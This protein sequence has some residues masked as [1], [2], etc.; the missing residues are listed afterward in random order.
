MAS[1]IKRV[2]FFG[3]GNVE[4]SIA[5]TSPVNGNGTIITSMLENSIAQG[6][7]I[8][9]KS[10]EVLIKEKTTNNIYPVA[11]QITDTVVPPPKELLLNKLFLNPGD[12]IVCNGANSVLL[13]KLTKQT[14]L[15]YLASY[16]GRSA[17]VN[18]DGSVL[19][20]YGAGI[21]LRST[22]KGSTFTKVLTVPS[23]TAK[24]FMM[25]FKG[26]FFIYTGNGFVYKSAD[27]I[28]WTSLATN[29]NTLNA[30]GVLNNFNT[31]GGIAS[32]AS[33]A[34]V[35]ITT[36][37]QYP[38][39][40]TSDGITWANDLTIPSPSIPVL[41]NGSPTGN[42]TFAT[43]LAMEIVGDLFYLITN[44]SNVIGGYVLDRITK[45]LKWP[46]NIYIADV[47]AKLVYARNFYIVNGML[48]FNNSGSIHYVT[49]SGV[50]VTLPF[51]SISKLWVG[52]N[53]FVFYNGASTKW[54]IYKVT[55]DGLDV[56]Y[57]ATIK[58]VYYDNRATA[59]AEMVLGI[60]GA[61]GG[62]YDSSNNELIVNT[63]FFTLLIPKITGNEFTY[64]VND[65]LSYADGNSITMSIIEV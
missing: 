23:I 11:P 51:T 1:T 22:D 64:T 28:T 24:P 38:I 42:F 63:K 62:S 52:K 65:D 55:D 2:S 31:R 39:Y 29:F 6:S 32:D 10:C 25:F 27:G 40:S 34:Y 60:A 46:I 20:V 7:P 37:Q 15:A 44:T 49:S 18:G 50:G 45:A 41:S 36:V 48:I 35:C 26:F 17:A 47:N 14:L 5:Y 30:D 4:Q 8:D 12:S 59:G 57:F 3:N 54:L 19:I 33:K 16:Y 21:A 61:A 53:F 9:N 43:I 58:S 56:Q 13:K